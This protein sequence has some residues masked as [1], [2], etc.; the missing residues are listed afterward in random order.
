MRIT[1]GMLAI[2]ATVGWAGVVVALEQG[3]LAFVDTHW[4]GTSYL[5]GAVTLVGL[6]ALVLV[7]LGRA[8]RGWLLFTCAILPLAGEAT[9]P[10][11]PNE[12]TN[13]M[14]RQSVAALSVG[15]GATVGWG[16]VWYLWAGGL[17][18]A[19]PARW[20]GAA[21][22]LSLLSQSIQVGLQLLVPGIAL[23][24]LFALMPIVVARMPSDRWTVAESVAALGA[25][26][27]AAAVALVGALAT[28]LLGLGTTVGLQMLQ[29][30]P[31]VETA[32]E[33]LINP[34]AAPW[35]TRW[36][37]SSVSS[38]TY[39]LGLAGAAALYDQATQDA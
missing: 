14:L 6:V 24:V 27:A 9:M 31:P 4:A 13:A 29:G 28:T 22:V 8:G 3:R 19:G 5:A 7:S 2:L 20:V 30:Q 35:T 26:P 33:W 36:I 37:A 23:A 21:A 18:A 17:R 15:L 32:T 10:L 11:I 12:G 25:A 39:G 38:V 1:D 16:M 34:L